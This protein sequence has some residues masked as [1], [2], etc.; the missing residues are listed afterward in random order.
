MSPPLVFRPDQ[1][2]AALQV[3]DDAVADVVG[4]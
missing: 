3:F 1:A 4:G 2:E